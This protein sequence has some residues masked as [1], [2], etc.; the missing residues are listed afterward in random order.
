MKCEKEGF[1][2][3]LSCDILKIYEAS[4]ISGHMN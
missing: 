2:E 3:L 1:R 4:V